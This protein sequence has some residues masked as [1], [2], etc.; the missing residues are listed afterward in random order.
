M[1]KFSLNTNKNKKECFN[2]NIEIV[3]LQKRI[4]ITNRNTE[5]MQ[6]PT[7]SLTSTKW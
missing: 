2:I 4:L 7:I 1:K 6:F 5:L 3:S